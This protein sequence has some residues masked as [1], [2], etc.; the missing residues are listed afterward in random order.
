MS[1]ILCLFGFRHRSCISFV[2]ICSH[3]L[4]RSLHGIFTSVN[5]WQ[6]FLLSLRMHNRSTRPCLGLIVIVN[7]HVCVGYFCPFIGLT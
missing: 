1:F 4:L 5:M 6:I 2:F 7:R 3:V